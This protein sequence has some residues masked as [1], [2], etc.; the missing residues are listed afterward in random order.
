MNTAAIARNAPCPCGSGKRFKDC[1][2]AF[3]AAAGGP[4]TADELLRQAQVR[5][6]AN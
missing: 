6:A 1:H 2:G 3:G 5:F 4:T